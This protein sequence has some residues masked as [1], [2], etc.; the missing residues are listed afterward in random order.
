MGQDSVWI[1]HAG[2]IRAATLLSKGIRAIKQ[3]DE[4]PHQAPGFGEWCSLAL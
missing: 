3:A 2:V 1:T 4:W